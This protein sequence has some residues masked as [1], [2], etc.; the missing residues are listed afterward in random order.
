[1]NS[2]VKSSNTFSLWHARMGHASHNT[3]KQILHSCN[4][5]IK[6]VSEFCNA[7]AV[8]KIHQQPFPSSTTIYTTPL[9]VVFVDIWGYHMLIQFRVTDTISL[10][11]MLSQNTLGFISYI[12]N[13]KLLQCF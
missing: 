12:L 9:E 7:C 8:S 3:I 10:F 2:T 4:L 5:R 6:N 13:L 1:M 11:L